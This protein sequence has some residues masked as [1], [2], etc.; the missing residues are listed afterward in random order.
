MTKDQQQKFDV[1]NEHP[2]ILADLQQQYFTF[3]QDVTSNKLVN[4]PTELGH[5]GYDVINIPAHESFIEGDNISYAHGYG[6]SH[7][8]LSIK[9]AVQNAKIKWPVK[10][11][12]AGTYSLAIQYAN[13]SNTTMLTGNLNIFD[14]TYPLTVNLEHYIPTTNEGAQRYP[15]TSA[16]DLNWK[17]QPIGEFNLLADSGNL[18][19]AINSLTH[20]AETQELIIKGIVISKIK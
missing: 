3:Y 7:D 16:P 20:Q 12:K 8:W 5:P 6:W 18:I 10:T 13:K 14:Q 15:T 4:I 19:I 17:T 9:P 2:A 1:S 11:V